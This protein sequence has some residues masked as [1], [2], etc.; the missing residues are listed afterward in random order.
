MLTNLACSTVSHGVPRWRAT[1]YGVSSRSSP[2]FVKDLV[3]VSSE[4]RKSLSRLLRLG[5]GLHLHLSSDLVIVRPDQICFRWGGGGG[6]HL[7]GDRRASPLPLWRLARRLV[8]KQCSHFQLDL[9][10]SRG[11]AGMDLQGNTNRIDKR[12]RPPTVKCFSSFPRSLPPLPPP[13]SYISLYSHL[14][15]RS[16]ALP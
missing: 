3:F 10:P 11:M 13:S 1:A 12:S 5:L 7:K 2:Y 14:P 16:N 8:Q 4:L 15:L 9:L 6:V